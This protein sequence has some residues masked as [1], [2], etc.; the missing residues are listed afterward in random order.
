[1]KTDIELQKLLAE[2]LPELLSSVKL[3][4]AV[5]PY[6]MFRFVDT[7]EMV[8]PREWLW[9]VAECEKKLTGLMDRVNYINNLRQLFQRPFSDLDL[10]CATWQ[11][12][13]TAYFKTIGKI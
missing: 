6:Y 9:I 4:D 5:K 10:V 8:N 12:R 3:T 13:A 1:M 11:Q 7:G 2:E